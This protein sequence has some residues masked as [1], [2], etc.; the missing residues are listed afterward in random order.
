MTLAVMVRFF[1]NMAYGTVIQ[2]TPEVMPTS[3]RASG[4]SLVHVSA[5]AAVTLSPFIIY[6]VS[7][8]GPVCVDTHCVHEQRMLQDNKIKD[9]IVSFIVYII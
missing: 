3:V 8:T 2:W 5:F 4:A 9:I 6:S 7:A 1:N